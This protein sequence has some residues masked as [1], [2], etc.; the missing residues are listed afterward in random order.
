MYRLPIKALI[1]GIFLLISSFSQK[2][3]PVKFLSEK[4][5]KRI[6]VSVSKRMH[7]CT[8][9][10]HTQTFLSYFWDHNPGLKAWIYST[11]PS[12]PALLI[13]YSSPSFF[14]PSVSQPAD[15]STLGQVFSVCLVGWLLDPYPNTLHILFDGQLAATSLKGHWGLDVRFKAGLSYW[16]GADTISVSSF[17]FTSSYTNDLI[18]SSNAPSSY[19]SQVIYCILS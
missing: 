17:L 7:T 12:P 5:R 15:T 1:P 13:L 10:E 14:L 3:P 9:A 8:N 6:L 19:I 16:K 2:Y 18:L 4:D 11:A